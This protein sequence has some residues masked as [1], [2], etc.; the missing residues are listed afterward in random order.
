[1][2]CSRW[3]QNSCWL[4]GLGP[5]GWEVVEPGFQSGSANLGTS[6]SMCCAPTSASLP[7]ALLSLSHGPVLQDALRSQAPSLGGGGRAGKP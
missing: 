6:S 2:L 4:G 1:M 7:R 3:S 5:C